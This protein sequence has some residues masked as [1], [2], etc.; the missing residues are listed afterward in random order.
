MKQRNRWII[1]FLIWSVAIQAQTPLELKFQAFQSSEECRQA[2]TGIHAVDVATGRTLIAQNSHMILNPA[3]ALKLVTSAAALELLG[4]DYR[5]QTRL[6]YTGKIVDGVLRGDLVVRGGGDPV[7]GSLYFRD[8]YFVPHFLDLWIQQVRAAGITRVEGALVMDGSLYDAEK[9]PPTW[10]WEDLGNYF[11]AGANALSL[12]DNQFQIT[13]RSPRRAGELTSVISVFPEASGFV[14]NNEV[15]ASDDPRDLAWIFGSPIDK[16]RTIRGTIPKNRRAFSIRAANP[17]PE[18]MLA[19]AF[20]TRL[21]QA[22]IFVSGGIRYGETSPVKLNEIFV[23]QSPPLAEIV[24]VLNHRS[25][26]LIAEHLVKQI[27]AERSGFGSR[28]AGLQIISNHW[29]EKGLDSRSLMMEDG[30]GLSTRNGVTP[31]FLTAMLRYLAQKSPVS[32]SF[33]RSLPVAGQGTLSRFSPSSFPESTLRAK[34]GTMTRVQCYA[35][36]I[37]NSAGKKIAFAL[38]VNNFS[39]SNA[40]LVAG[41][42]KILLEIRNGKGTF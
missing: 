29:Q 8:H 39:G 7:L 9:V 40:K 14:W 16:T 11:G 33:V 5:F 6:G 42:E 30:S 25:V 10:L 27:A 38:M 1:P 37:Q 32:E 12:Y 24:R 41:I 4:S 35:G 36:Y 23:T 15:L 28:E 19:G 3:S 20:L 22:A 31:E 34:S 21:D 2:W 26:N 18:E 17:F 13:L